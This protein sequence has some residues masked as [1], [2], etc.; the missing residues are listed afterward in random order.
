M[1]F[2]PFSWLR[3]KVKTA[4]LGGIQD[5]VEELDVVDG[6]ENNPATLANRVKA[7]TAPP[8]A[9]ETEAET[10]PVRGRKKS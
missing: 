4:F 6:E 3:E 8:E 2:D 10:K 9:E 7:L 1:A 5:A